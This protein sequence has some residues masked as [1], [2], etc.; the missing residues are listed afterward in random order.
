MFEYQSPKTLDNI[1]FKCKWD[2]NIGTVSGG[3]FDTGMMGANFRHGDTKD[4]VKN[5]HREE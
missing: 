2:S 5:M 4:N 1:G 3:F